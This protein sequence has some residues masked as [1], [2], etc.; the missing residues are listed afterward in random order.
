MRPFLH[1]STLCQRFVNFV[2]GN[3][4]L[5]IASDYWSHATFS[6]HTCSSSFDYL[7]PMRVPIH[8]WDVG[9]C[10]G[11]LARFG[12]GLAVSL[13]KCATEKS[14]G[15]AIFIEQI[16][17][18]YETLALTWKIEMTEDWLLCISFAMMA[19]QKSFY[20]YFLVTLLKYFEGKS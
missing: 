11:S 10:A 2:I 5:V 3:A 13:T 14:H 7:S 18:N 9:L 12:F 4:L 17:M 20:Y 19:K 6:T 8:R 1:L 16:F 15:G